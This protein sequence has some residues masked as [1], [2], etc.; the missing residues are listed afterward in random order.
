MVVVGAAIVVLAIAAA[1]VVGAGWSRSTGNLRV[2]RQLS[3]S[4]T[5]VNSDGSQICLVASSGQDLCGQVMQVPGSA[6][7]SVGEEVSFADSWIAD[8]DAQREV[9]IVTAPAPS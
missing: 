6:P 2:D 7:L 3:G 1:F 8:G 4:I 9:L 5:R